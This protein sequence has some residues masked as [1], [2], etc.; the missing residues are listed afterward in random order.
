MAV[1]DPDS[2]TQ[3]KQMALKIG[4]QKKVQFIDGQQVELMSDEEEELSSQTAGVVMSDE[5]G[6]PYVVLEVTS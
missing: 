2:S 6:R 3:E 5:T 4:R 1:H